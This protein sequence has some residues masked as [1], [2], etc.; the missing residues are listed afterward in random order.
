MVDVMTAY[1]DEAFYKDEYL[2][3]KEAVINAAFYFYARRATQE[4]RRF[5]GS[6]VEES[7]IPECVK[8]CCC[9]VAELLYNAESTESG[10]AAQGISSESVGDMSVS[11]ESA[12]TRHQA[13]M[14]NIKSVVYSWLAGTGLLYRGVRR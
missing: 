2:C 5:T 13:L 3:G 4:I 8:M 10:S 9:E 11:Y 7:D 12:E 14:N 6:N 1:A